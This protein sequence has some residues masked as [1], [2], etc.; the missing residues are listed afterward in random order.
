MTELHALG[1]LRVPPSD[2]IDISLLLLLSLSHFRAHFFEVHH[3]GLVE[4]SRVASDSRRHRLFLSSV[5]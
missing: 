5:F 2:L 1:Y 4:R 3:G